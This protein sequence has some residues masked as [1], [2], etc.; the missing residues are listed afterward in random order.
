MVDY[1]LAPDHPFPAALDDCVTAY[2]WLLGQG[3]SPQN[4]VLAGDSAGGN[5]GDHHDEA[6]RGRR[7]LAGRGRL[8]SSPVADLS[9]HP[10]PAEGSGDPLLPPKAMRFYSASYVASTQRCD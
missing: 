10:S 4:V 9:D 3:I 7:A 2:R 1:R 5:R 6:A 8:L